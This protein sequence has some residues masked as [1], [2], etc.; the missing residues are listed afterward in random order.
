MS[1]RLVGVNFSVIVVCFISS[2]SALAKLICWEKLSRR[3]ANLDR[4]YSRNS[5]TLTKQ[6][7]YYLMSFL[8][9]ITSYFRLALG[10]NA[11]SEGVELSCHSEDGGQFK[12]RLGCTFRI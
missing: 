3:G 5:A 6:V 1:R 9:T 7:A 8:K 10:K 2:G 12:K 4:V 11:Y